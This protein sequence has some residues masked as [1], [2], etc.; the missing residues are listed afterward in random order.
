MA[1][2]WLKDTN[3]LALEHKTKVGENKE[4]IQNN[5]E[6][7]QGNVTEIFCLKT[8]QELQED[9]IGSLEGQIRNQE[10]TLSFQEQK[11]EKFEGLIR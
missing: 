11:L 9:K 7:I 4:N 2:S 6:N 10:T 8:N 1:F 5:K 3:N